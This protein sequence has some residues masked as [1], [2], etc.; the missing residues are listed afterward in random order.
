MKKITLLI[1][2]ISCGL[3]AQEAYY[4]DVNLTLTGNDLYMA[5]QT[6]IN[7]GVSSSFNYGDNRDTM[8]ITDDED[9]ANTAGDNVSAIVWLIYGHTDDGNCTTDRTRNE[10]DF[11]GVSCDYN[12]EHTYARTLPVPDMGSVS[13]SS[14]GI[15]ADPHNIRPSDQQMNNNKGSRLFTSGSGN[16]GTSGAFWYPGDEW[17]GDVA[18]ILM[19]MYTRY[20]DRC[21][22]EYAANGTKQGTTDMLQIL[23]QW[24]DEDNVSAF[25][26]QRNEYLEGLYGNRN[27]FIDNPYFATA[28]WGG[29]EATD[30]WG[31]LG[32]EEN[33]SVSFSMFPN[34]L[35][36]NIL[37][38]KNA[39]NSSILIFDV[40]G[41]KVFEKTIL[42]NTSRL[43]LSQLN[44]GMYF[45]QI[46]NKN[47]SVIKK[48]IKR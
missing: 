7:T 41:K 31:V 10:D 22:P 9:F 36:D 46:E 27:P 20:G 48:L 15:G 14:T 13:N 5:L 42:E 45:V 2:L 23:L 25:E 38:I 29:P 12:R 24:N 40:L 19:Y 4:N 33:E 32:I 43:N 21:L 11:G 47:S 8:K 44:N 3:F 1:L 34:P 16:A 18:R 6:K 35:N 28:I 26:Y 17:K 37:T 39:E 30:T